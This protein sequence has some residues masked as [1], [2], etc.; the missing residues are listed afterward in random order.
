[1]CVERVGKDKDKDA[2]ENVDAD[3]KSTER[4]VSGQPTGLITQLEEMDIDF[5]VS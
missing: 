4:L 5:R 3:Q 2:D 1:M